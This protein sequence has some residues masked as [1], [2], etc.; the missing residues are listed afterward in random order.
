MNSE[1]FSKTETDSK[2]RS[3]IILFRSGDIRNQLAI[4]V[5]GYPKFAPNRDTFGPL[6]FEGRVSGLRYSVGYD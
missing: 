5:V 1:Q 6:I 4:E 3:T 2:R